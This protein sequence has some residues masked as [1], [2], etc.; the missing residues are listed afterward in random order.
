[1]YQLV[2]RRT[3]Q[4]IAR[5][6]AI[7]RTVDQ[8]LR[9]LDAKADRERLGLNINPPLV[10]HL[11]GVARAVADCEHQMIGGDAVAIVQNDPR[12]LSFAIA[13]L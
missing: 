9:M 6:L 8:R 7:A 4:R 2:I 3:E 10:Q 5:I 1:M 12:D 11:K 13:A